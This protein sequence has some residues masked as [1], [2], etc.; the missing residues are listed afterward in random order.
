MYANLRVTPEDGEPMNAYLVEV[1]KDGTMLV[2]L[3]AN[4][5]GRDAVPAGI[6]R[7]TGNEKL[8]IEAD[9]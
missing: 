7:V 2:H 9:F 8:T 1:E 6:V 4:D 3:D 5:G